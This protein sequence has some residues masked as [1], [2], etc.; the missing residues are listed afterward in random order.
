[1]TI[2]SLGVIIPKKKT[3]GAN[4]VYLAFF[5]CLFFLKRKQGWVSKLGNVADF[6]KQNL[7]TTYQRKKDEENEKYN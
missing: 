6:P 1:M 4:R 7:K 5:F 2:G 3:C